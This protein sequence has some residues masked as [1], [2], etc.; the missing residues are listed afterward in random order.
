MQAVTI[1]GV[2]VSV[3]SYWFRGLARYFLYLE[4]LIGI[5][6]LFYPN[7]NRSFSNTYFIAIEYGSYILAFYCGSMR[8]VYFALLTMIFAMFFNDHVAY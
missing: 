5:A 8:S 2:I 1:V 4:M 3:L 7:S 6:T